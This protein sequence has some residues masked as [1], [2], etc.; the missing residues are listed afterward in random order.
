MDLKTSEPV[1]TLQLGFGC[2]GGHA[3][4]AVEIFVSRGRAL[5][6]Q[7]QSVGSETENSHVGGIEN[8]KMKHVD[9]HGWDAKSKFQT[10]ID[11]FKVHR[12][13]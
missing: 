3:K 4:N 13:Y 6:P 7:K 1:S 12:F 10:E 8:L 11:T 5:G 9:F 2:V